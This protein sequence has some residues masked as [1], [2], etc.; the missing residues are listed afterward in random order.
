MQ[1]FSIPIAEARGNRE[2]IWVPTHAERNSH[3]FHPCTPFLVKY[4]TVSADD[5]LN[6]WAM[7]LL[8]RVYYYDKAEWQKQFPKAQI[9]TSKDLEKS[10]VYL[11]VAFVIGGEIESDYKDNSIL[12]GVT[13]GGLA[14]KDT[15]EGTGVKGFNPQNAINK[16]KPA[17]IEKVK[18]FKHL[19]E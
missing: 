6:P 7:V 8:A 13:N 17:T 14:L 16:N 4:L 11:S 1:G 19:Y 18:T 2:A 12:T 10:Y 9:P 15:F 3:V 5:Y